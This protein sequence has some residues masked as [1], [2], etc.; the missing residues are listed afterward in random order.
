MVWKRFGSGYKEAILESSIFLAPALILAV[1][2][3][4]KGFSHSFQVGGTD[5]L[6]F[7]WVIAVA[8]VFKFAIVDGLARYTP[9]KGE[10]IFSSL[11]D[12][13]G[14]R[15]WGIWV[16][17]GIYTFELMA[18]SSIA[19]FAA[20]VLDE[21]LPGEQTVSVIAILIVITVLV[22][23]LW[24]SLG[25]LERTVY[26]IIAVVILLMA[27]TL[28]ATVVFGSSASLVHG[29]GWA[30]LVDDF[31]LLVGSG[32]GLALLLYSEW[33]GEKIK[34]VPAGMSRP[35]VL[36]GLRTSLVFAFLITGV[37][38]LIIMTVAASAGTGDMAD[39]NGME[40]GGLPMAVPA[41]I[42]SVG[43]LMFGILYVGID[44]RARAISRMLRRLGSLRW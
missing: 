44:G 26:F 22:M 5:G 9:A 18:Y 30:S 41:F 25:F 19:L 23:L 20:S 11:P 8:L 12:L 40:L 43:I 32:S 31:M 14:P 24:R 42:M 13:P 27:Y 37:F 33:V 28:V 4:G 38:S 35:K 1:Q 3:S 34:R 29:P 6:S 36:A 10:S 16:V 39:M 7:I 2:M 21:L 15:H 17:I